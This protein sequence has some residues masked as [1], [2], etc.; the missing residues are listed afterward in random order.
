[1]FRSR[2]RNLIAAIGVGI[3]ASATSACAGV[4]FIAFGVA[5]PA[6]ETLVTDFSAIRP[7]EHANLVTGSQL[8]VSLAPSYGSSTNYDQLQYLS[9]PTGGWA[10]IAFSPTL[11]VSTYVGSLDTWN[12]VTFSGPGATAFT[13]TELGLI[14]GAADGDPT[15]PY[16]NGRFVFTFARPVTSVTFSASHPAFEIADVGIGPSVINGAPEPGTWLLMCLGL[17]GAGASLRRRNRAAAPLP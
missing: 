17:A 5:L 9:V 7:F 2:T 14:S 8:D 13:G 10:T 6:G 3:A 1:M 11:E 16:T 12:F 15:S 4:G